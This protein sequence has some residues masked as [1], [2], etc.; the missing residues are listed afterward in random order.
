MDSNCIRERGG[1]MYFKANR[2]WVVILSA[3]M[4]SSVFWYLPPPGKA[5]AA[6]TSR[7]TAAKGRGFA[8]LMQRWKYKLQKQDQNNTNQKEVVGYYTKDW[9]NDN[10]SQFS[11]MNYSTYITG[12]ATFTFRLDSSG[13]LI[14]TQHKEAIKISQDNNIEV[15]ALIHN[16]TSA[17]FDSNLIHSILSDPR[18]RTRTILNI[19]NMLIGSGYDGVNIDFENV[20][21]TD[22]DALVKFMTELQ[23]KLEP[24][25]YKVTMSVPAKTWDNPRDGWSGA[26]DYK[27]LGQVVDRIMLMTY[28]EHWLGGAPGP[29]ASK[30]WVEKVVAYAVQVV[31][32]EKLLLGI[33]NYGYDW[34]VGQGGYK[35]VPA[36]KTI[37]LA[38]QYGATINWDNNQ[39]TPY[40]YYWKNSSKHVV[41]FES[42]QSS[43]VKV[44][45]VKKQG[46]KG[47]AIWRLGFEEASFWR[48]VE[49]KLIN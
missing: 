2:I 8:S 20:P 36:K 16:L 30:P 5:E 45:L 6:T 4:F 26:F 42:I 44:D 43:A 22:R 28:D 31:P 41:W 12:I 11:L 15:Y 19:Y 33:G 24:D 47:I 1:E 27:S 21:V 40:F 7:I 23:E 10:M 32:R 18:L 9:S 13:K 39:G 3:L 14:G 25:G 34:I 37:P 38:K 49:D 48:M 29:V 17:G 46:L 35:A